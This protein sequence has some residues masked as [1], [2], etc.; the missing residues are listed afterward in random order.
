MPKAPR[1]WENFQG[2]ISGQCSTQDQF[3]SVTKMPLLSFQSAEVHMPIKK[4]IL[5]LAMK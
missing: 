1:I 4:T 5:P 2:R 3:I